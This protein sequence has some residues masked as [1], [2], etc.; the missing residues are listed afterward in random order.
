MARK[1]FVPVQKWLIC[2]ISSLDSKFNPRRMSNTPPVKF[3][4]RLDLEQIILF[5]DG[6]RFI[7]VHIH[8]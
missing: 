6:H 1:L 2:S 3:I 4:V 7:P 5:L 8:E